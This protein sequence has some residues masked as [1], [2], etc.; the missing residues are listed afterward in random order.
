MPYVGESLT[1]L[2]GEKVQEVTRRA[3]HNMADRGGERMVELTKMNTPIDTGELR[4]SWK[5]TPVHPEPRGED[6]AYSTGVES[7]VS[8]APYVEY[9]TG[10]WGPKHSKYPILPKNAPYLQWFDKASGH[11]V[12]AKKVMHPGSPGQ[13]MVAIAASVLEFEVAGALMDPILDRWVHEAEGAAG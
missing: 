2:F 1:S 12:R 7:H 8:Y 13:H 6:M 10:L 11:W 5:Q 3:A 9:G 4:E